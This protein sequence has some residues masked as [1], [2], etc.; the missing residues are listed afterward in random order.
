M[1][2]PSAHTEKVGGGLI[3]AWFLPV[4]ENRSFIFMWWQPEMAGHSSRDLT[5]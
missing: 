4:R 2:L 3:T 1:P 5:V